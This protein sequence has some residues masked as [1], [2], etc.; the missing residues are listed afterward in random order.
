MNSIISN[1]NN[2]NEK[3][4]DEFTV[5]FQQSIVNGEKSVKVFFNNKQAGDVINDNSRIEDFYRYHDVF[6]YTFATLLNWSPCTR[7]MLGK[8]RKSNPDIDEYED[9]ARA[10]ITE[11]AISLMIFSEAKKRNYFLSNEVPESILDLIK[12]MTQPFEVNIKSKLEWKKAI[13]EGYKLFRLLIKNDGGFIEFNRKSKT[14]H[15]CAV[16]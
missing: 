16:A 13:I 2:F 8:K 14:A 5:L 10:T 11:E 1:N 4:P 3:I 6:H 12:Q 9:G 7:A 15:Y